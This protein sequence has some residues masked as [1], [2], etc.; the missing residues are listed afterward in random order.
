[1]PERIAVEEGALYHV[2]AGTWVRFYDQNV[3]RPR[4]DAWAR[5]MSHPSS[6]EDVDVFVAVD[7][8]VAVRGMVPQAALTRVTEGQ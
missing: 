4:A 5:E 2:T 6:G 3:A 7:N 1:M 8:A